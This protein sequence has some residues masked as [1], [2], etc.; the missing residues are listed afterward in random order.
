VNEAEYKVMGIAPYGEPR[1]VDELSCV[2]RTYE[3]GSFWLDLD[4]FSFH[5]SARKAYTDKLPAL[6]EPG[7]GSGTSPSIPTW[8][9]GRFEFGPRAVGNRSV[10][11][12][13]RLPRDQGADQ[14]VDQVGEPFQPFAPAATEE[15]AETLVSPEQAHQH[16]ARFTL[17]IYEL[18]PQIANRIGAVNDS[19]PRGFRQSARP[20]TLRFFHLL[21]RLGERTEL[22]VLLNTSFNLRREPIVA[23]RDDDPRLAAPRGR[24][25]EEKASAGRGR[26]ARRGRAPRRRG[27][28]DGL[29]ALVTRAGLKPVPAALGWSS[30]ASEAAG[31]GR[32]SRPLGTLSA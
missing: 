1:F 28:P 8:Y 11:A 30:E 6:R 18:E 5:Y 10:L 23:S 16:P 32:L 3:D 4:D 7:R 22:P 17:L 15:L 26:V 13:L 31:L 24:G 25:V 19:A 29:S 2:L 9:Q 21:E 20:G 27:R 14:R 12:D